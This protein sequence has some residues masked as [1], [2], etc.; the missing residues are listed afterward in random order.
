MFVNTGGHLCH[1]SINTLS[2]Q[3]IGFT[4]KPRG[5][6]PV[7]V[8]QGSHF[9]ADN[10]DVPEDSRQTHRHHLSSFHSTTR[11]QR[12]EPFFMYPDSISK[13][14]RY[15]GVGGSSLSFPVTVTKCLTEITQGRS[16]LF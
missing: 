6:S 10:G 2:D 15:G 13:R 7:D 4:S 3:F 12:V 5:D 14:S 11:P 1:L 16:G 9:R 8:S